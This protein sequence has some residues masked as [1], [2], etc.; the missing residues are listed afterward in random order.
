MRPR[1]C[2]SLPCELGKFGALRNGALACHCAENIRAFT[3]GWD[4]EHLHKQKE[5]LEGALF[6]ILKLMQKSYTVPQDDLMLP[7]EERKYVLKVR[8][9]PPEKKPRERLLAHGPEPLS[10][11]EL[12]AIVLSV[13]TKKEEVLS[14][15]SRILKEYGAKSIMAQTNPEQMAADLGVPVGKAMQIVAC[16]ELGRRFFHKNGNG[17]PVIRTARDVFDYLGEIRDLPKEHLR[18]I[19][20]N[21][22]YKVIHDETISIGTLDASLIHPREVFKPA[23]D[24]SAAAVIVAHN[25]PSEVT[26]P[27]D[28]DLRVT[29]QLVAVGQL[30]G[31]PL[32]DHV[33][34]TKTSFVSVPV[35]YS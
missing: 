17:A 25:H 32:I 19:Y 30:L 20:L 24:Y 14:M 31:V 11:H 12:L 16:A 15:S 22:H 7:Q 34:L 26:D 33:I 10:T 2:T 13:G 8:D 28:A 35:E 1:L 29:K 9:L 21:A 23:L 6:A 3:P 5:L 27:S 18:G 4:K